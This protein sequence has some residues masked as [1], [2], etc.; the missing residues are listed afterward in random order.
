MKKARNALELIGGTPMVRLN[1]VVPPGAAEVWAK[2]EGNNP[3]GS[4]KDRIA[5]AMIEAAEAEGKLQPGGTI[6]EPTSGNTGI[7]LALVAAVKGY[8]LI[9]TMFDT[10]SRE[11]RLQI[12]AYGAEVVL[13]PAAEGMRGAIQKALELKQ[14]HPEYFL[15]QQFLNP[16]NPEI[17]RRT[18]GAEILEQME[19]QVDAFVAGVGTGGSITGVGEAL[20][21]ALPGVRI[22]AV[23][24]Q[25][26]PVLS[27]GEPG[28]SYIEGL[29]AGFVPQVLNRR[30]IDEVRTISD[31]DAYDMTRRLAR[32]EGLL[33]G[34]SAGANAAMA[35][36]IA[37]E[38]GPG[39]KVV[40]LLCDDGL[41]YLSTR[42]FE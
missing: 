23:E 26:S 38:L 7:G 2:V 16:A 40:T 5:L 4:V 29:G 12:Q 25:G 39:R 19:G 33:V 15:P 9:V 21:A 10:A 24:P 30:I 35:A 18:T 20:K 36:A 6:V 32:E 31:D 41:R 34:I 8:R 3:A 13:T 28:F 42:V 1:R 11:R 17:H 22:I 27:G 37:G 14:E